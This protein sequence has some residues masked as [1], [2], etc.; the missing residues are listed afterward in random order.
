MSPLA[1]S[2]LPPGIGRAA[3][4]APVYMILQP[5][6]CTAS[7]IATGTGGLLPHLFTLTPETGAVIF[8]YISFALTSNF[9]LGSMALC[10]AR[11]FL[12]LYSQRQTCLLHFANI[13]NS[14]KIQ[15]IR[16]NKNKEF[17]VVLK[18]QIKIIVHYFIKSSKFALSIFIKK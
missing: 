8:C 18:N 14:K 5:M 7:G 6:R 10:V 17:N 2:D 11:T 9:P 3:L 15:I 1:S 13:V 12:W 16:N 4:H